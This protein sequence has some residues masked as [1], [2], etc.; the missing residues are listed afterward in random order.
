MAR[1]VI[2]LDTLADGVQSVADLEVGDT[3]EAQILLKADASEQYDGVEFH[4]SYDPAVL[5]ATSIVSESSAELPLPIFPAA[6]DNTLGEIDFAR[7]ILAASSS[8]DLV[9]ATITFQVVGAGST[10]LAFGGSLDPSFVSFQGNN[11]LEGTD[12]ATVSVGGANTPPVASDDTASTSEDTP[13]TVSVLDNDADADG[14]AV[15]VTGASDPANGSAEVNSDGTIT[16]TPDAEFNGTDSFTY[17]VSDGNGGTATATVEVTVNAVDDAPVASDDTGFSTPFNT[18]LEINAADLL[19]N[20]DDG[21]P[22]LTQALSV[23]GV[24]AASGGTVGLDNGVITFTPTPGSTGAASFEYTMTDGSGE[25]ATATV[26]VSVGANTPPVASDDTASTSEDTAVTV[27]V[28]DN[29]GDADGDAVVVTGASDP[30]NGS[31]EVNSDGT[32]TYTPDAEFNGTDSFTYDVSDGNGGTDTAT[33]EVTVNGTARMVIDTDT[34]AAGVQSVADLA[35]GDSF[36]VLVLLETGAGQQYDA[37]EFHLDFDPAVLAATGITVLSGAELPLELVPAAF[38]NSAGTIDFVRGAL[39]NFPSGSLALARIS[40]DV[41]GSGSTDLAFND[42][43][44]RE[45][46]VTF[47]GASIL[48]GTDGATVNATA[49]NTPPVAS[50]DTASTSEDTPVT[51]SVLDNDADADGDAIVVT[52]I[53]GVDATVDTAILLPSGATATLRSDGTISYDPNGAFDGLNAGQSGA[54]SFSYVIADAQGSEATAQVDVSVNGKDDT[55][56]SDGIGLWLFEEGAPGRDETEQDNTALFRNGAFVSGGAAQFDG[57]ND[58]VE[59]PDLPLYDLDEGSIAITLTVA[60]LNGLSGLFSRDSSGYDGGGHVSAWVDNGGAVLVRHQT[61]STSYTVETAAGVVSEGEQISLVYRFSDAGGME[62]LQDD[63]LGN[64]TLLAQNAS[65]DVSLAGNDEPWVVGAAQSR[66][67]DGVADRIEDFLEGSI[68]RFEI[69]TG[70]P[71]SVDPNLPPTA[72]PD[73]AT[74]QEDSALTNIAVLGND[75]DADGDLPLVLAG[76]VQPANGTVTQNADGTL[77]YTPDA[78]FFGTDVVLYTVR[79]ARGATSQGVLTIEVSP[80]DDPAIANDDSGATLVNTPVA[81]S[82][83]ANDIDVDGP[84]PSIASFDAT[85]ANGGTITSAGGVLTY[86]P[87]AGFEGADSFGYTL[88]GG[89]SAVVTVN[90]SNPNLPPT[91][92]PDNATSQEDTALTNIAVLGNDGDADGDL[93]LALAGVVQPANGTVTQNSDG[94]LNYTPDADFFGTDVVLYTVRDA[95]GATSQGVLT[96]E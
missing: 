35:V 32:I 40:F 43:F 78:D 89:D 4:I 79:D 54:D 50:D 74:T 81:I 73:S 3:F 85:S 21:D 64:L 10:D 36:E 63:G 25:S 88:A 24:G 60:D 71:P 34:S 45:T 49:Q 77:N 8:G 62:L 28:L 96:I 91:A 76:V 70:A 47:A 93:P 27:S 57:V 39:T 30:A 51:V 83:L 22:E 44:P 20:D 23:T 17:D 48:D 55:P 41:V 69:Y 56:G 92:A 66:S 1:I 61:T 72:A 38:D 31:V 33:V 18:A 19:A 7:G 42:A 14:D 12:T 87:A 9:L 94:T 53:A 6:F 65:A 13:V 37:A 15:V 16:Y 59:I 90:V 46:G 29:D 68:D 75:G 26:S 80:V 11:I 67:G 52:K 95:R 84:A 5:S 86:T 82:V 2:D 58:Y